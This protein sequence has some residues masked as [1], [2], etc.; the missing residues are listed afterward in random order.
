M[1]A[2]HNNRRHRYMIVLRASAITGAESHHEFMLD[3]EHQYVTKKDL[4]K[5][6][7]MLSNMPERLEFAVVQSVS[8][9]GFTSE[10]E[11]HGNV[12]SDN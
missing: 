7:E 4:N 10:S 6:K 5:C 9:L 1:A 3:T 8:Y 2:N 11:F 12:D